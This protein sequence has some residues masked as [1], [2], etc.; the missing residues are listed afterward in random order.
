M[1][2]TNSKPDRIT[3]DPTEK[4]PIVLPDFDLSA[5]SSIPFN[6]RFLNP[7]ILVNAPNPIM[8]LLD[9][10]C[11]RRTSR[12]YSSRKVDMKTF[13][14]L[15]TYAM[16][17]PTAC[18][19]QKWK[20]IYIDDLDIFSELTRRGSASFLKNVRQ[21]M[22]LCYNRQTD[23]IHWADHI[24]SGAALITTFQ[25]LAHSTGIGSCWINHLPN[26]PEIRRLFK[27]DH[28]Y[29]PIAL[30]SFGYYNDKVRFLPRKHDSSHVVMINRFESGRLVLKDSRSGF[31]RRWA[32]FIYYKI[33]AFIRCRLQPYALKYE[34]KFYNEIFD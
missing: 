21:A 26:K 4:P 18:N 19:E 5:Q 3:A 10:V 31:V 8:P 32:R 1:R 6:G 13:H 24:Q 23:N 17:A 20:V 34:R 14:W 30:V 33:P 25:L 16:N 12:A 2:V 22:L 9:A 28:A 7:G 29:D 11:T 27:I 15:I